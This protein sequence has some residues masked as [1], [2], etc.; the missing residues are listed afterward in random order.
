[1][2]RPLKWTSNAIAQTKTWFGSPTRRRA[3][4]AVA[5]LVLGILCVFP[6]QYV[7]RVKILPQHSNSGVSAL[8]GALGGGAQ[9]FAAFLS[10]QQT[11]YLVIG[12][13]HDVVQVVIKRLGLVERRGF[14]D[15]RQAEL[16][17]EKKVDIQILTGGVL[18]ITAK[19]S[20]P[21]F[22]REL[23]TG[24]A[25]AIDDRL[26]ALGQELIDRKKATILAKLTEANKKAADAEVALTTFR[27]ANRLASPQVEFGAALSRKLAL[28]GQLDSKAVELR[29]AE[30][31]ATGDNMRLKTIRSEIASLRQQVA[32][33]EAADS[34]AGVEQLAK[35]SADYVNLY[36]DV[37]F[38]QYISDIY[39][40]FYEEV[41]VEEMSSDTNLQTIE[42]PYI[43]PGLHI[44]NVAAG[45]LF[46]VALIAFYTDYY[47][48]MT[49][50]GRPRGRTARTGADQ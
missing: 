14:R 48:P 21:R 35:K 50:L 5:V 17:L 27:A 10:G 23:V 39:K 13:S 22:A 9:N 28:Q 15:L 30:Q 46:L 34:G 37:Q 6:R 4:Y 7:A 20:D 24:F 25:G 1:M 8:I 12:R 3:F 26:A 49:G 11:N 29:A 2:D 41:T 44:N 18:E 36:R 38:Y 16:T 19:D 47:I 31:F 33:A 40:R 43:D 32:I 42:A 45:L